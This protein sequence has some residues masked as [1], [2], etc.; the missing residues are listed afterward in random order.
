LR[1]A[2]RNTRPGVASPRLYLTWRALEATKVAL[3]NI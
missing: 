2:S 3:L 1:L